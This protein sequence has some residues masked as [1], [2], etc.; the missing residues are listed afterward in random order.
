MRVSPGERAR[1]GCEDGQLMSWVHWCSSGAPFGLSTFH[2][3]TAAYIE[4]VLPAVDVMLEALGCFFMHQYVPLSSIRSRYLAHLTT[5]LR[6]LQLSP[7]SIAARLDPGRDSVEG[8]HVLYPCPFWRVRPPFSPSA[9][10][11]R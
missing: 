4:P 5:Q 10:Y 1:E 8:A 2:Q 7:S 3:L 11:H 9:S 6:Y